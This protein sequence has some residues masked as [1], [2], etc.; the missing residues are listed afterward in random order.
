M[1]T[2]LRQ[3][4]TC[5]LPREKFVRHGT[6]GVTERDL[7]AILLRTGTR[8][9]SVLELADAVLRQ[10]PQE[11][12]YY[13]GESSVADL[14]RIRGIGQDKAI[15]L[16][17]AVELG[18]RIAK[19]RV[20]Q[21]APDFSTP[22]AI[23]EYVMEDMRTAFLPYNKSRRQGNETSSIHG[24]VLVYSF[25]SGRRYSGRHFGRCPVGGKRGKCD[26]LIDPSL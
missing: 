25:F 5:D 4:L 9:L 15:T 10:L 14:C 24:C 22:Q 23:A 6:A 1:S 20:K 26:A 8:G 12:I 11:N 2:L 13:L 16:C 3:S 7:L 19:Q 21:Q 17:A 18:R